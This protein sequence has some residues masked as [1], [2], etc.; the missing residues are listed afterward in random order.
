MI[1]RPPREQ[2]TITAINSSSDRPTRDYNERGK[3]GRRNGIE[4]RKRRGKRRRRKR[5]EEVEERKERRGGYHFIITLSNRTFR[6][7]AFVS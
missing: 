4:D 5:K 3:K 6:R 7:V 1:R 2:A